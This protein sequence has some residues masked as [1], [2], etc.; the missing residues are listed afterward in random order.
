MTYPTIKYSEDTEITTRNVYP[1]LKNLNLYEFYEELD[2]VLGRSSDSEK[3]CAQCTNYIASQQSTG[4]ELIDLCKKV[5][6]IILNVNGVLDKCKNNTADKPCQYMSYWLYNNVMR[7]SNNLP[8]I[9]S[10]Y[11]I[12]GAFTSSRNHYFKNCTLTNFNIDKEEFYKKHILYEF[13]ESY[14]HMKKNIDNQI[15]L[16]TPLYCKHVKE[17]FN[18]YNRIKDNCNSN[19]C[20]YYEDLQK[21]KGKF[22]N[23]EELNFIY[24]ICKYKKTSCKYGSNAEDDVPCLVPQGNPLLFQI[25]GN[26]PYNIINVLLNIAIISVPT[27]TIFLI[28]FKFTPFGRKLN[29]IKAKGR[30]NGS[31]KK[32]ENIED[33]MNN[34]AV[35]VDNITKNRVNV[36]YHAS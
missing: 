10:L 24:D 4:E 36:A 11:H 14:D 34:Y 21:F 22:N 26:D 13:L 30:K 35:Y 32:E 7:I 12:L 16:Y 31:K 28:L 33:Y 17:N 25:F 9:R 8:L 23:P 5:C 18:I 29:R 20:K 6:N 2:N 19:T 1:L 27:L 15:E 3:K